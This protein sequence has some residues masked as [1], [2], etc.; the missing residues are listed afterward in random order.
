VRASALRQAL[1]AALA[2]AFLLQAEFVAFHFHVARVGAHAAATDL[3]RQDLSKGHKH[4]QLPDDT[5]PIC[6]QLANTSAYL[7][8]ASAGIPLPEMVASHPY[9]MR[10]DTQPVAPIALNW[11]SRA[12]PSPAQT[13]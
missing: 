2:F 12:P 1:I 8:S 4:H 13:I 5:C 10:D 9:A 3:E 6:Q 7:H 11:R